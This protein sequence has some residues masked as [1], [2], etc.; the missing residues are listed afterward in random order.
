[1]PHRHPWFQAV[2]RLFSFGAA[3][4]DLRTRLEAEDEAALRGARGTTPI[5]EVA[6]REKVCL[7][8]VVQSMTY[9]AI[10]RPAQLNAILYDGTGTVELRWLGRRDI[11]GIRVGLHLEVEGTATPQGDHMVIMN[12][13]Y[14]ILPH[15]Q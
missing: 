15:V 8:G 14:R 7:S 12:P 4:T 9:S 13:L 2:A 1:M 5:A 6:A 11:P 10:G 3:R